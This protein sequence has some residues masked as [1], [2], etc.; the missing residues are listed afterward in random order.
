VK[1]RPVKKRPV[2]KRPVKK[3]MA[4]RTRRL[5]I[6][7]IAAGDFVAWR[8]AHRSA[9]PSRNAWDRG[10][11]PE[12]ELTRD[13]FREFL[14]SQR[15]NRKSEQFYD[16]SVFLAST[17]ERVGSVG[18]MNVVRGVSQSAFLGYTIFNRHWGKGY[19]REAV[20]AAFDVAFTDLGLHRL[21]A[22]VEPG[23][24]RS[25]RLARSLGMRKEGKKLRCIRQRGGWRDLLIY[26]L[27]CE[28]LGVQFR[29]SIA[30]R[31]S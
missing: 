19:G 28:D 8:D 17:G 7:P 31:P 30:T 6:R 27:T 5:M 11:R 20:S 15:A 29:G 10:R 1:K 25:I 22:G 2:K 14:T 9:Q 12:S 4:R 24:L 21:E 16:L 13:R 3:R 26:S 23:N 18:I